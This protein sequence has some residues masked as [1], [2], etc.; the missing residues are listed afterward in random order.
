MVVRGN[1]PA[2]GHESTIR[3]SPFRDGALFMEDKRRYRRYSISSVGRIFFGGDDVGGEIFLGNIGRGGIG[4][5]ARRG[6]PSGV[7]GRIEFPYFDSGGD[8]QVADL[9]GSVVWSLGGEELIR[10]GFAFGREIRPGSHEKLSDLLDH[11][12]RTA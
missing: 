4:F 6:L 5:R 1:R 2:G 11:Q 8:V 12:E 10:M 9:D 7:S 3:G